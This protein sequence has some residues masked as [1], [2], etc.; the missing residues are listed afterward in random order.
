MV[1]GED[2]EWLVDLGEIGWNADYP[3]LGSWPRR[4]IVAGDRAAIEGA[5]E[6]N[7]FRFSGRDAQVRRDPH[8]DIA[9]HPRLA[10]QP[11]RLRQLHRV[12]DFEFLVIGNREGTV[13]ALDD[14][15]AGRA[16]SITAAD[17][18]QLDAA[19]LSRLE[20]GRTW[21]NLDGAIRRLEDDGRQVK[22]LLEDGP[23]Y[24]SFDRSISLVGPGLRKRKYG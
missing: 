13:P 21:R 22:P 1:Q 8:S 5:P 11:P 10:S 4:R 12:E 15:S 6:A 17:P 19:F 2:G 3:N 24:Q 23:I 7:L 20:Q 18:R 14:A 9:K 16:D